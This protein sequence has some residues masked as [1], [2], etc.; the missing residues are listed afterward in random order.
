MSSRVSHAERAAVHFAAEII[1]ARGRTSSK[2][3]QAAGKL[4]R[5]ILPT[6]MRDALATANLLGHLTC[7]HNMFDSKWY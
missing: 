7:A 2:D 5:R 3:L 4:A 1:M 6:T